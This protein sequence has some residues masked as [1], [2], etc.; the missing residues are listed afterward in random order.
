MSESRGFVEQS[1]TSTKTGVTGSEGAEQLVG[2]AGAPIDRP[3]PGETVEIATEMGATYVLNFD[4]SE[5]RVLVE[6]DDLILLFDDGSRI[7]FENLV[8]VAQLEDGPSLQYAGEDL[9]P[10]L[11]AQGAIPGVEGNFELIQPES[12]EIV[13]IIAG[14]GQRYNI[15]FD[16]A[17]AQVQVDG[18]NPSLLFPDGGQI[19]F[20]DLGIVGQ[21]DGAPIF[22]IAGTEIPSGGFFTQALA[23]TE[24]GY[25]H[26]NHHLATLRR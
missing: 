23:L 5:A 25:C 18:N 17:V 2:Q 6:G 8:T 20:V 11:L 15:N 19:V 7:V 26:V 10:L 24:A 14:L 1:E 13:T 12:G 21:Q 22:E 3:G 4:P 9:I 16:P